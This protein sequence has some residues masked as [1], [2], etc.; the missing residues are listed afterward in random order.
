MEQHRS[1]AIEQPTGTMISCESIQY[2]LSASELQRQTI[3]SEVEAQ[4]SVEQRYNCQRFSKV[5]MGNKL[6]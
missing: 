5:H 6:R 1:A 2:Q 3:C 4:R